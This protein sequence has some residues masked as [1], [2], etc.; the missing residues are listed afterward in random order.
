MFPPLPWVLGYSGTPFV[1]LCHAI[2]PQNEVDSVEGP[3]ISRLASCLFRTLA[4][5]GAIQKLRWGSVLG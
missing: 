1:P 2:F 3:R 4:V 5:G